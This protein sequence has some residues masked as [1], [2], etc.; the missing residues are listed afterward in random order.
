MGQKY[1]I[2]AHI[3]D[4]PIVEISD[5]LVRA[6]YRSGGRH[7]ENSLSVKTLAKTGDRITRALARYAAGEQNVIVDD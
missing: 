4:P 7:M 2:I 6:R 5:G 3:T 1:E